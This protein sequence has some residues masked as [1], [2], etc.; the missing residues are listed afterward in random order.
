MKRVSFV[1]LFVLFVFLF[2]AV[3]IPPPVISQKPAPESAAKGR[4]IFAQSCASC[5]EVLGTTIKSG[6]ALKDYYRRQPR[7]ADA[8]VRAI[9]EQGKGRMPAFT[10][11]DQLQ[12]DD[13]VAYLKTL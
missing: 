13:L 2:F 1:V 4:R 10:S 8:T 6:P 7:P 9:I 5:H 11:L 3:T 12:V